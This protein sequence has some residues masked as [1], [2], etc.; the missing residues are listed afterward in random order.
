MLTARSNSYH[1]ASLLAVGLLIIGEMTPAF[2]SSPKTLDWTNITPDQMEQFKQ[3]RQAFRQAEAAGRNEAIHEFEAQQ[4]ERVVGNQADYDVHYYGI[5]LSLDFAGQTVTGFVDYRVESLVSALGTV[6]LNLR[7]ELS[8]D[9]VVVAGTG[10][11]FSH[12]N[13]LLTV[14]LPTN[15]G[16]GSMVE[17]Q[18]Y[19]HGTPYY[20][21]SAGLTF[22]NQFGTDLCWTKATPYRSRYWWPCKDFPI[23]KPD[24]IDLYMEFPEQYDIATNGYLVSST[25]LGNGRKLEHWKHGYPIATYL[26]AFCVATYDKVVQ[27]WGFAADTIPFYTYSLPGNTEAMD[28]FQTYGPEV[29]T[30]WSNLFG[31]YP[32]ITEKMGEG[33]FGWSG[34]MEHQTFCMYSTDF[35]TDWVIA[36]ETAHQWWGDM[37]TCKTFNHIW[38]NEGFATYCEALFYEQ[39]QGS[40]AYHNYMSSLKYYG[41]GTIY[42]ENLVYE[43]IYD[44]NLSYNK[45]AWVL[46]MLRGVLGDSLFFQALRDFANSQYRYG[47]AT[48]EDF[49]SVVSA[50]AGEDISWFTNEWIYGEGYPAY[51]YGWE[52]KSDS[53]GYNLSLFVEQTQSFPTIFSMPIKTRFQTTGGIVDT[54]LWNSGGFAYYSLTFPD[55]VTAVSLDPE[56]WILRTTTQVPFGVKVT[57]RTLP[58]APEGE[59]YSQTLNAVGGHPPYTWSFFGGDIPYGL[60]FD[61]PTAT[62]SGTPTY[63][64]TYYF[65]IVCE[66]SSDPTLSDSIGLV[67]TVTPPPGVCGDADGSGAVAISDA[68]YIINYIFGG[69]PAPDPLTIGDADC[70]GGISVA[71]AVY[72]IN[73]IFGGGP[74]PCAACP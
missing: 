64:A 42:V 74:D 36:H 63:Q 61:A 19:Y 69:G 70:S 23:D 3:Q 39:T 28:A 60:T 5:H 18:V 37:I 59:P 56:Q 26:V 15:Y 67:I 27:D 14:N 41:P 4:T 2:A 6:D 72:I 21:G 65:T 68:V 45:G 30:L 17:M 57:T 73:Y 1:V 22:T 71:D 11:T 40:A 62:I 43:D 51:A 29:L 16:S 25:S 24:S 55:S 13:H 66:D 31:E 46:H 20:D 44:G 9:S 58:D 8:V 33:D 52:C 47:D 35:H 34:A 50:T 32:F 10:T 48:T 49:A 54:T 12:V 7:N 53:V 38:I